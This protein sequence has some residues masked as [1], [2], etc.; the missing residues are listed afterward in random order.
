VTLYL[1]AGGNRIRRPGDARLL[2]R[3]LGLSAGLLVSPL[4]LWV[5]APALLCL[6]L[7]FALSLPMMGALWLLRRWLRFTDDESFSGDGLPPAVTFTLV[8]AYYLH[9]KRPRKRN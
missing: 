9:R 4:L 5:I 1:V 3:L 7:F 2:V 6:A 8:P